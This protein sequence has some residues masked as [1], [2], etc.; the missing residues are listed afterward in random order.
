VE[1]LCDLLTE[2]GFQV[3]TANSV[4]AARSM[5]LE[6]VD[7]IVSDIGLPD[8][9]GLDL[10]RELRMRTNRPAI[11]LSG[12]GMESDVNAAEDAGF[13]LH[14]TKPVDI[15]RLLSAIENLCRK[16]RRVRSGEPSSHDHGSPD[17]LHS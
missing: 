5:D 9:S 15:D 17:Q 11:A 12:F 2:N 7:V 6:H 1:I 4:A 14:L 16:A 10:M 8:G 3:E 13:D